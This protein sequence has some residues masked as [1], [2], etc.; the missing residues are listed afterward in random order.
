MLKKIEVFK[1][2]ETERENDTDERRDKWHEWNG[3]ER[4]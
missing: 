2:M 4:E 3:I 1:T